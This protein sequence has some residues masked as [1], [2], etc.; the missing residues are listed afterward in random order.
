MCILL[1]CVLKCSAGLREL[2]MSYSYV[3]CLRNLWLGIFQNGCFKGFLHM[4][5]ILSV[6]S[7]LQTGRERRVCESIFP[8]SAC[9]F[10][11]PA[12]GRQECGR[13]STRSWRRG[14]QG[15]WMWSSNAVQTWTQPAEA[16]TGCW[17]SKGCCNRVECFLS[18]LGLLGVE[19][20]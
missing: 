3:K 20:Y 11:D 5:A 17:K 7:L 4:K 16:E 15:G 13:A 1:F 12:G 6:Y 18:V 14:R 10:A 8:A 19:K 9:G 2:T